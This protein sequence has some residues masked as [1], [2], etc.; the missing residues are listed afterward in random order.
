MDIILIKINNKVIFTKKEKQLIKKQFWFN[1]GLIVIVYT[2]F[3]SIKRSET[4]INPPFYETSFLRGLF[5]YYTINF[6]I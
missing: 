2:I 5:Y 1:G 4:S 6:N 3:R